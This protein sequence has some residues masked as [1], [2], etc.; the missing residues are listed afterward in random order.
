MPGVLANCQQLDQ[1]FFH[2]FTERIA[3]STHTFLHVFSQEIHSSLVRN[4]G[5][6]RG[7]RIRRSLFPCHAESRGS[8]APRLSSKGTSKSSVSTSILPRVRSGWSESKRFTC[9]S[10]RPVCAPLVER[11]ANDLRFTGSVSPTPARATIVVASFRRANT[12]SARP[13][14]SNSWTACFDQAARLR[15][16]KFRNFAEWH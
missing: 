9:L 5:R 1:R 11:R 3:N 14:F 7:T 8:R 16:E 12:A 10:L 4:L 15:A 13:S 2:R 6:K